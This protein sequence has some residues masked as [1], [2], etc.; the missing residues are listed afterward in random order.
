LLHLNANSDIQNNDIL[1]SLCKGAIFVVLFWSS[2]TC[3]HLILRVRIEKWIKMKFVG[4][5]SIWLLSI[6]RNVKYTNNKYHKDRL[7]QFVSLSSSFIVKG[8]ILFG[9]GD[10]KCKLCKSHAK[11]SGV[12]YNKQNKHQL[13]H[14]IASVQTFTTL[15]YKGSTCNTNSDS[16]YDNLKNVLH[17]PFNGNVLVFKRTTFCENVWGVWRLKCPCYDFRQKISW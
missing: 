10:A 6:P 14:R 11:W 17:E 4:I 5:R 9:Q 1:S 8:S 3:K 12:R 13:L 15:Q 2:Q 7:N 16:K